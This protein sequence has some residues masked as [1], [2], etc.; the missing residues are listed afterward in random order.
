[1]K[2]VSKP[3]AAPPLQPPALERHY[4]CFEIAERWGLS[5]K[6]VREMFR[7]DPRVLKIG[8]KGR[9]RKRDYV[10]LRVPASVV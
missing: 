1:M 5:T 7:D 9:R 6:T 8:L 3:I 10:T 2:S 4:S